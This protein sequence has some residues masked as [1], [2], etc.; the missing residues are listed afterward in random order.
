M[1]KFLYLTHGFVLSIGS[2]III[3]VFKRDT[4]VYVPP[5]DVLPPIIFSV[6][7]F[8]LFVHLG[9][10]ST[11]KLKT[12]GLIASLLIMGFLIFW[13]VFAVIVLTTLMCLLLVKIIL[14]RVNYDH[15]H[16]IS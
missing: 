8:F 12:A 3:Y 9:Y 14:K 4:I 1:K 11:H 5:S 13:P 7:L 10:L 15:A 6:I 16:F 2:S